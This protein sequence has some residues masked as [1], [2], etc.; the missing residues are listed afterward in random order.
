[1]NRKRDDPLSEI[2]KF[3]LDSLIINGNI[4]LAY[5]ISHP[6]SKEGEYLHTLALRW[7]RSETSRAYLNEQASKVCFI[8]DK[9]KEEKREISID[10]TKK[11]NI[12]NA[13]SIAANAERDNLKRSKILAQIA[14]LQRMK[15]DENNNE[16]ELL[17]FYFPLNCKRCPLYIQMQKK[18]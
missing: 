17:H 11:D 7:K 2:E 14:D 1:M 15:A 10:Y 8:G 3:C 6:N 13:L 16:E 9:S 18:I 4:D 12:I 5:K